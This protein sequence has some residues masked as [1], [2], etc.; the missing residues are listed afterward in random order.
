MDEETTQLA[1]K[2]TLVSKAVL[3]LLYNTISKNMYEMHT[4]LRGI[5]IS[6]YVGVFFFK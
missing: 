2:L 6:S 4:A 1:I 5:K 3:Y